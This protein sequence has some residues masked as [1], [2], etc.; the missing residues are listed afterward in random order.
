MKNVC[1]VL[2]RVS[3]SVESNRDGDDI[4]ARKYAGLLVAFDVWRGSRY[5][6]SHAG[7]AATRHEQSLPLSEGAPPGLLARQEE[8]C[9][10]VHT[11]IVQYDVGDLLIL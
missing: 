4:T 10:A 8:F 3:C 2:Q 5:G 11:S 6:T 1:F 7:L 9:V